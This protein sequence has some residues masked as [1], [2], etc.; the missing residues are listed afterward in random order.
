MSRPI[1]RDTTI[2][3]DVISAIKNYSFNNLS[4]FYRRFKSMLHISRATFFRVMSTES[5]TMENVINIESLARRLNLMD[6]GGGSSYGAKRELTIDLVNA[7]KDFL[8]DS[9]D[10]NRDRLKR[11]IVQ[12]E[13]LL[14]S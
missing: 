7:V 9:S 13:P 14:I 11:Y 2:S 8:K 6:K 10:L 12:Y 4:E 5:T 1:L 3:R